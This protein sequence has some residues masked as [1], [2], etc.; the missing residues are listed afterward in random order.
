MDAPVTHDY[1]CR[2]GFVMRPVRAG[3]SRADLFCG[4]CQHGPRMG[5]KCLFHPERRILPWTEPEP[6]QRQRLCPVCGNPIG[7]T[8]RLCKEHAGELTRL[9]DRAR[10]RLVVDH[11]RLGFL[12]SCV[13]A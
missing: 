4:H 5:D 9:S 8:A 2:E 6:T 12:L 10:K 11:S 1:A 7:R 13:G 3:Q